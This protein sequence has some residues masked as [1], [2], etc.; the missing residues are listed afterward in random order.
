MKNQA[1]KRRAPGLQACGAALV[2]LTLLSACGGGSVSTGPGP[3]PPTTLLPRSNPVPLAPTMACSTAGQA[4]AQAS[5]ATAVV[6]MLTSDGEMVVELYGDKA[7]KT[8][9]NF[10][11]YVSTKYYDNTIFHRVVPN[12]VVQGGGVAPGGITA[13]GLVLKPGV[14][15]PIVSESKNGLSN[16]R[17]NI[18]MAR[19]SDP[20]SATSQFYFNTVDNSACLDAGTVKCDPSGVGY[21]VFGKVIAGLA[22]LDKINAEPQLAPGA[23]TP[24]V[25]VML[26]WVQRLK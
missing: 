6:C 23:D 21:T 19:T 20:N 11:S 17:G 22:T 7:P 2:A 26:Y 3:T 18:A 14:Q 5:S 15:P 9:A 4:A 1:M 25:E 10:L 8:V 16:L 24:S 12:F 13:T